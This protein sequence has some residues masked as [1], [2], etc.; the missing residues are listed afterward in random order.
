[1]NHQIFGKIAL[2]ALILVSCNTAKKVAV[3]EA[4]D[5]IYN[6]PAK[7]STL[8]ANQLKTWSHADLATDTI[9]GISLAKAYQF[10][11]GKKSTTVIAAVADTGIDIDH[12]DL[13]P[14]MWT[15][16][17]DSA[18]GKDNDGNGFVDDINGWN[19]L[20]D[21]Y[22]E[23]LE[24]T[25]MVRLGKKRFGDRTAAEITP[26]EM[27]D[28][29]QFKKLEKEVKAKFAGSGTYF[30]VDFNAR[31]NMPDPYSMEVKVYG[32]ANIKNSIASESHASHVAG[33]IGAARGNGKGIDGIANN[34]KIMS[35][36]V[37]PRGDEYDKDVALGIRYAVDNGA[38]VIN[39]SFGKSHSPNREWVYEAIEYAAEKDVVIVMSSGNNGQNVDAEPTF[40]NDS[41][42]NSTEISDNVIM[43]G[44][45]TFNYDSSLPAAF[46]NYGKKH[47]DIF[48]PGVSIYSTVPAG[49]YRAMGGTSMASPAVAGVVALIRSY[50]P[51][52]TAKQ[53][54]QIIMKSG[55]K[56]DFDVMT[57]GSE[58]TLVPLTEL[59]VS[60]RILNAYEAVK[61][62]DKLSK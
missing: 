16:S 29:R 49:K 9:P 7:T 55:T 52:L 62:A 6:L 27:A 25:R 20:G 1:M 8:T 3:P 54:K 51:K 4:S 26:D 13:G 35:L 31:E 34:V 56:I 42:D 5:E 53:V 48:A 50:Y 37:V 61:M 10:L 17:D 41:R 11:E 22:D 15:N 43:V 38:S 24:M 33:I 30:N 59:C 32:N 39:A 60:G 44:A 21:T 57:P 58:P 28:F 19:F 12:E 46:S 45:S 40:P 2:A 47:V 23:N 18:D 36:R 14:V